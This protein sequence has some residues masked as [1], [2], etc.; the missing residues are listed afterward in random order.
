M[1][2]K[3]KPPSEA[4][5]ANARPSTM[6]VM[7]PQRQASNRLVSKGK[8]LIDSGDFDRAAGVLMDA[9]NVDSSNGV[10]YYYLAVANVKLGNNEVAAGLLDKAEAQLGAD[11]EWQSKIN[12]LRAGLG[13]PEPT[14]VVQSPID[15]SF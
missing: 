12:Q 9:V 1:P 2:D 8:A 7:T 10:A 4:Q 11:E 3:Q 5:R 14:P 15:V 13:I 6:D